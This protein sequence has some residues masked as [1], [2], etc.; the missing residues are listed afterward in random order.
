M[1]YKICDAISDNLQIKVND[2]NMIIWL[3]VLYNHTHNQGT[4]R[5]QKTIHMLKLITQQQ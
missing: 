3:I 4:M 5:N 1:K 2:T